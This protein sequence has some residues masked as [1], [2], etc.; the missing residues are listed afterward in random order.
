MSVVSEV[1]L[2]K[3]GWYV[4]AEGARSL[5]TKDLT[6]TEVDCMKRVKKAIKNSR[7]TN[8]MKR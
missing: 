6:E 7:P 4:K 5:F 8:P 3:G 2:K 1:H